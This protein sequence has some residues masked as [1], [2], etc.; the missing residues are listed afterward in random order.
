MYIYLKVNEKEQRQYDFFIRFTANE[1]VDE[2]K[3]IAKE[4]QH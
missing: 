2:T 4:P 3:A 1:F